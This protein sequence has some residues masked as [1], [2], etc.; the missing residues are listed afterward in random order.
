MQAFVLPYYNLYFETVLGFSRQQIG[1]L[2]ALRPWLS[3][4]CAM[5]LCA[6]ADRWRVHTALLVGCFSA[7]VVL[8]CLMMV[9]P[10][11][12]L[13]V[14]A[15]GESRGADMPE[16]RACLLAAG[17]FAACSDNLLAAG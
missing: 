3:A 7:S 10:G 8:R 9:V 11:N 2:S 14:G 1:L 12:L 5:L 4:P 16:V 13:A 6:V 17:E 15:V